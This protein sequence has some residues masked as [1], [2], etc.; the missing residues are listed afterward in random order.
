MKLFDAFACLL[1]AC[2]V[3]LLFMTVGVGDHGYK[4][5]LWM[6]LFY[7]FILLCSFPFW[8]FTFAPLYLI[9][10]ANSFFWR[11]YVAPVIGALIGFVSGM[12]VFAPTQY[13][14]YDFPRQYL[15]P[16]VIGF[17]TFFAGSLLKKFSVT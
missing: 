17:V 1:L 3:G 13:E 10:S 5:A 14:F 2:L 4:W 6:S 15:A 8:L 9:T 16:L 12:L 7:A 11:W